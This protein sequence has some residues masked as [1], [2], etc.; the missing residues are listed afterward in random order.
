MQASTAKFLS[1][2]VTI[3]IGHINRLLYITLNSANYQRFSV[4][5]ITSGRENTRGIA[6]K[7]PVPRETS[8][9]APFGAWA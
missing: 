8:T 3:L 6:A 1:S 9:L 2:C 5:N 7:L 4:T